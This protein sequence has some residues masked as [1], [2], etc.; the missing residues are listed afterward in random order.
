MTIQ[1][2]P[3]MRCV[4]LFLCPSLANCPPSCWLK[5]MSLL[6]LHECPQLAKPLQWI[7]LECYK[8][9]IT[10]NWH[11][12]Y[13]CPEKRFSTL[14]LEIHF[15]AEFSA[16]NLDQTHF[17]SSKTL[18]SLCR[19]ELNSAEKWTS[20]ARVEKPLS[21]IL[22]FLSQSMIRSYKKSQKDAFFLQMLLITSLGRCMARSLVSII[23]LNY[24][25]I[26]VLFQLNMLPYTLIA[27]RVI[28]LSII[29]ITVK[30]KDN[31]YQRIIFN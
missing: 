13:H 12:L 17:F 8:P 2:I 4:P 29:G 7:E 6:T 5:C 31:V 14:A 28:E 10:W 11:S 25:I 19:L 9:L 30:N 1:E 15:T 18:I 16:S 26:S 27:W 22:Y 21:R 3:N 24:I 20:R 23:T